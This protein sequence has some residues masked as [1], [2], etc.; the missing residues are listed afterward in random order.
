MST[1]AVLIAP[2]KGPLL[3]LV[4]SFFLIIG[5]QPCRRANT[6]SESV[7]KQ[8]RRL[9]NSGFVRVLVQLKAGQQLHRPPPSGSS[10]GRSQV[11]LLA[12]PSTM[13][14][15]HADSVYSWA[16]K[17][18]TISEPHSSSARY[19]L[20]QRGNMSKTRILL[21]GAD[22]FM[23]SHILAQ[24]LSHDDLSVRAVLNTAEAVPA[25]QNHYQRI[26]PSSVDFA[27][28]SEYNCLVPGIFEDALRD[29]S[30]PFHAVVHTLSNK[31]SD[32]V[33]CLARFIKLR[34]DAI[35]GFLISVQAASHVVSRVV[36]VGSLIPFARWLGDPPTLRL[37]YQGTP[38]NST[39]PIVD[40][41]HILATSQASSNI[42]SDAV[43]TW[44]K[45]SGAR[46][47]IVFVTAPSVYGPA[48]HPLENSS[49]LTETNRRIWNIC[50][51]EPL[52]QATRPPYGINQFSDVRVRLSI[53]FEVASINHLN[54]ISPMLPSGHCSANEL[55]ISIWLCQRGL[56]PQGLRLR[57]ISQLDSLN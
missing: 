48:V 44:A 40:T 5:T 19:H 32:E 50:S 42:V 51:N 56:C 28:V 52:E 46:F 9:P 26:Y 20:Q 15:P 12:A 1:G 14:H 13:R 29:S 49:E 18:H 21:T 17:P 37:S 8:L 41:E 57:N 31:S 30:E 6:R 7:W 2:P 53:G 43:L 38:G 23:G 10:T 47:N 55:Q 45:Q 54:R 22:T 36:I 27:T 11:V 34:T 4:C 16:K 35:I 3:L 39:Y 25:L 33:D 24:L